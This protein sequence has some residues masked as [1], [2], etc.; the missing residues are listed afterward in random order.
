MSELS[1]PSSVYRIDRF[2]VPRAAAAAFLAR[3]HQIDGLLAGQPGC[4]QH[5]VLSSAADADTQQVITLVEWA[6]A[7]AM[8]AARAVAQQRYVEEGFDPPAFMRSLGVLP[9]LRVFQPA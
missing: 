1:S 3:L 4:R 6:D 8:Q 7:A 2:V 9:E 5:L